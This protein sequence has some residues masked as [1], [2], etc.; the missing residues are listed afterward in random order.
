MKILQNLVSDNHKSSMFFD[1]VVATQNG[2][3]LRTYQDGEIG[4]NNKHYIGVEI[5]ELGQQGLINDTDIENED[6]VDIMV[7]KFIAIYKEGSNEPI[8]NLF[9]FDNYDDA[10]DG[11]KE[12]H[13]ILINTN[14]DE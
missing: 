6:I 8:H 1:G 2:Y 5:R 13:D 9:I 10:I 12:L 7:D 14:S 11:L 3:E 4:F